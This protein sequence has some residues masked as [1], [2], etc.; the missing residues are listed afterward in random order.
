MTHR[1]MFLQIITLT[2]Y[3][4]HDIYTFGCVTGARILLVSL[5]LQRG[6]NG[7]QPP[8]GNTT[9][10]TYRIPRTHAPTDLHR[11]PVGCDIL[12]YSVCAWPDIDC[13]RRDGSCCGSRYCWRAH[14][15]PAGH[16]MVVGNLDWPHQCPRFDLCD[17]ADGVVFLY[18]CN[19]P[20]V[21]TYCCDDAC[22]A[23][24]CAGTGTACRSSTAVTCVGLDQCGDYLN[25][26]ACQSCPG[27]LSRGC[28]CAARCRRG[29]H[30][31][32]MGSR[33][34]YRTLPRRTPPAGHPDHGEHLCSCLAPADS[35]VVWH[36]ASQRR[37]RPTVGTPDLV[38]R[39]CNL[40][41]LSERTHPPLRTLSRSCMSGPGVASE[42]SA[43]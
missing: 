5:F 10:S 35:L 20:A 40:V 29:E 21:T 3:N 31:C 9:D 8:S 16:A 1:S 18:W 25:C 22:N 43:T 15:P 34:V 33:L 19:C 13:A 30:V 12:V 39:G 37:H 6:C 36:H 14:V 17:P 11:H 32:G 42:Y 27:A 7:R 38:R 26:L 2:S 4:C 23:R 28:W 24:L 41:A